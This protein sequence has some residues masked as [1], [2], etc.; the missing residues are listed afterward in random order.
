[1]TGGGG[2]IAN[3]M[4]EEELAGYYVE[5]GDGAKNGRVPGARLKADDIVF[6]PDQILG[7]GADAMGLGLERG[8]TLAQFSR[9]CEGLHPHTG[10][11]LVDPGHAPVYEV[12]VAG[13]VVTDDF[14]K[15]L[16]ARDP[17]TGKAL[18]KE[19]H[20]AGIDVYLAAPKSVTLAAAVAAEVNP[21][22]YKRIIEA[23]KGAVVATM[24]WVETNALLGRR[25]IATPSEVG[26]RVVTKGPRQGLACKTQGS[27]TERVAMDLVIVTAAQHTARPTEATTE[28]GAPPDPHLHSHNVI[29]NM[30][31]DRETDKVQGIDDYSLKTTAV[32]R[33]ARYLGELTRRLE[34]AGVEID[35]GSESPGVDEFADSRRGRLPWKVRGITDEAVDHFSSNRNRA[36]DLARDYEEETG[37]TATAVVLKERMKGTRR[38]KGDFAEMDRS[39]VHRLWRE[40]A[41]RCG[42]TMADPDLIERLRD[43]AH[44][45]RRAPTDARVEVLRRRLDGPKGLA[46]KDATFNAATVT[47]ALARSAEGLGFTPDELD[48]LELDVF[49]SLVVARQ[50]NDPR[51][52]LYTTETVLSAETYIAATLAAKA[53]AAYPRPSAGAVAR[54][55]ADSPVRDDAEQRGVVGQLASSRGLVFVTGPAGTGKTTAAKPALQAMRAEGI[56]DQVVVVSTASRT[57]LGSGAKLKAEWSGSIEKFTWATEHGQLRM[58][59]KTVIVLDES[60]QPGTDRMENLLKTA[61]PARL[62]CLGDIEQAQPIGASG[63]HADATDALGTETLTAVYRHEDPRDTADFTMLR[64]GG[65][66]DEVIASLAGRDRFHVSEDRQS[67]LGRILEDYRDHRNRGLGAEDVKII[68]DGHN[69]EV[70]TANRQ[71]QRWRR[72]HAEISSTEAFTVRSE[73]EDRQWTLCAGDQVLTLTPYKAND[74][75]RIPNGTSAMLA[76]ITSDGKAVLVLKD[77]RRVAV[78]L[79]ASAE[80]QPVGLAY[81]VHAQKFQGAEVPVVLALPGGGTDKFSGYSALTRC[82]QETHVYADR[83]THGEDPEASLARAW[84]GAEQSRSA[85]RVMSQGAGSG[86][87]N[88]SQTTGDY[89]DKASAERH[90]DRLARVIGPEAVAQVRA[91]DA[92]PALVQGLNSLDASGANTAAMVRTIGQGRT[93]QGVDDPAAVLVARLANTPRIELANPYG[94]SLAPPLPTRPLPSSAEPPRPGSPNGRSGA[95]GPGQQQDRLARAFDLSGGSSKTNVDRHMDQLERVIGPAAVAQVKSAPAYPDLTQR[96]AALDANGANTTAMLRN[97]ARR[98]TDGA[99]RGVEGAAD[100]ARELVTRLDD[101]GRK[102]ARPQDPMARAFDLSGGVRGG[103]RTN[104]ETSLSIDPRISRALGNTPAAVETAAAVRAAP[105]IRPW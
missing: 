105:P 57:A 41:E 75:K 102:R 70:D 78:A 12:D 103:R 98:N 15:P 49:E 53:A 51:H 93:L 76:S 56:V 61:G 72:A 67:S 26:A 34:D 27:K 17:E 55:V 16:Q 60:G 5:G 37:R 24:S 101:A 8:V 29:I 43:P 50:A 7:T 79:D 59:P 87:G 89:S 81:A 88:G 3:Y 47:E 62:W 38:S 36:F 80:R 32:E 28:R 4:L 68:L 94:P 65:R 6:R 39:P 91:A 14:G 9:M 33:D 96:L 73:S 21:E 90:M 22:M 42:I 58:T 74:G 82:T 63:W 46:M 35:F 99:L 92:Y 23:H 54:A 10:E 18:T 85:H 44:T 2:A 30:A 69:T 20:K 71:V 77:D 86:A 13:Q 64:A 100:P 52:T 66:A 25:T 83:E 97:A 31:R 84:N 95:P 40:D 11:R 1:M 104:T 19:V 48:R 45:V